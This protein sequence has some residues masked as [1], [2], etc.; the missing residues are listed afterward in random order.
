MAAG[1]VPLVISGME[2]DLS[3][4]LV[5]NSCG[6]SVRSGDI[7]G[8]KLAILTMAK[9]AELLNQYKMAARA[10]AEHLFSRRNTE[11]YIEALK[12][13]DLIE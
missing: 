8:L 11:Q 3:L 7:E 12:Q 2:T 9:D 10:T 5:K 13:Y 4:M 6:M 1:L